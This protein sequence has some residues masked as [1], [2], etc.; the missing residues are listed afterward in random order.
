MRS[1]Y[2]ESWLGNVAGAWRLLAPDANLAKMT[3]AKFE[4]L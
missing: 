4:E 2:A 3:L 1:K